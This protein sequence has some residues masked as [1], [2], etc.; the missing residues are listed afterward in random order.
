MPSNL[1]GGR[2]VATHRTSTACGMRS[3]HHPCCHASGSPE[4]V[5]LPL[6]PRDLHSSAVSRPLQSSLPDCGPPRHVSLPGHL[7]SQALRMP[8]AGCGAVL[9]ALLPVFAHMRCAYPRHTHTRP[10]PLAL[11]CTTL[12]D[13]I[14]A[15][16]SQYYLV[17]STWLLATILWIQLIADARQSSIDQRAAQKRNCV[18]TCPHRDW[19]LVARSGCKTGAV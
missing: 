15:V 1:S 9:R 4:A 7:R 8:V 6:S 13:P 10:P 11:C 16:H 2:C 5:H 17:R 12:S 18:V 14:A 19:S 3:V